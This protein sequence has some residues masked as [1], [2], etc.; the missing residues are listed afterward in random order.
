MTTNK[1]NFSI[2]LSVDASALDRHATMTD[3]AFA[4][5]VRKYV[6]R[7]EDHVV[8]KFDGDVTVKTT[9]G[10]TTVAVEDA[11]GADVS[12]DYADDVKDMSARIWSQICDELA[13]DE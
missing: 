10:Y 11:D 5:A 6:S 13:D 9:Q 4:A 2:K 8:G 7:V 12:D 1:L 3:A